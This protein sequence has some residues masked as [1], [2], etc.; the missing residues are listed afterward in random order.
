MGSKL[1][2]WGVIIDALDIAAWLAESLSNGSL[3][4]DYKIDVVFESQIKLV[5]KKTGT[6]PKTGEP[7]YEKYANL[8]YN[9][10]NKYLDPNFSLQGIIKGSVEM[11][12]SI[13]FQAKVKDWGQNPEED[14]YNKKAELKAG[15]KGSSYVTLTVPTELN[16]E[17]N[18]DVDLFFSGVKIEIWFKASIDSENPDGKPNY[19][20]KMIPKADLKKTI[21]F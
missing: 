4:I 5:G 6:D 14:K 9:F 13:R 2:P 11:S 18:L 15:I 3:E 21:E 17:G 16:S 7:Q 8:K 1:K 12:F 10:T 20:K 19:S